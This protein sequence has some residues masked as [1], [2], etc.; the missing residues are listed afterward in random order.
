MAAAT[1][2]AVALS[3]V[4]VASAEDTAFSLL[5]DI[6]KRVDKIEVVKY[7]LTHGIGCSFFFCMF[8]NL[9]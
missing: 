6:K 9:F 5:Q 3:D 1:V 7:F 8:G 2:G 4:G